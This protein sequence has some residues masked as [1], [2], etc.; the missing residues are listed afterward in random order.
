V[1]G[2]RGEHRIIFGPKLSRPTW[3]PKH[4]EITVVEKSINISSAHQA[5]SV[6]VKDRLIL[7]GTQN[8]QLKNYHDSKKNI[9][10]IKQQIQCYLLFG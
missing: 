6:P 4:G 7:A 3:H 8:T 9:I 5:S 10:L 2:S 1:G